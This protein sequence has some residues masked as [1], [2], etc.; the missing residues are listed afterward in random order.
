MTEAGEPKEGS[1][2]AGFDLPTNETAPSIARADAR[3]QL[4]RWSLSALVEPLSLVVSELVSNAVRHGH[5]PFKMLMR[6]LGGGVRVDVHD[7]GHTLDSEDPVSNP[8]NEG[9]RGLLIVKA[10]STDYGVDQIPD[11]GK[12]VWAVV[13]PKADAPE[14]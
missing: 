14:G 7:A 6:R 13:E 3:N 11:D 10:L 2:S 5:P 9:G 12:R 8:N 4:K 1:E